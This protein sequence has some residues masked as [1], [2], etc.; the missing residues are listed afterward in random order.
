MANIYMGE[1][2]IGTAAVVLNTADATA[3]AAD[4]MKDKTAYVGTEKV[5]GTHE[6]AT[7]EELLPELSNPAGAANIESGYQAI[8]ANGMKIIGSLVNNTV[9]VTNV[10]SILSGYAQWKNY[11]ITIPAIEGKENF[12]IMCMNH[13]SQDREYGH[14][15]G[16]VGD[17]NFSYADVSYNPGAITRSGTSAT[18]RVS[19]GKISYSAQTGWICIA[20]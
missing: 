13:F 6:C 11:D 4:I 7:L 12:I 8:D 15:F 1:Q 19:T 5:T 18:I 9:T 10:D 2:P 16:I 20:W 17:Y 3:T 14:C